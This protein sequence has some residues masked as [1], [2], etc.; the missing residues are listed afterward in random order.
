MRFAR[1]GRVDRSKNGVRHSEGVARLRRETEYAGGYRDGERS[2]H[3]R[4][5]W[6]DGHTYEGTWRA[7]MRHGAGTE[8]LRSGLSRRCTWKWGEVVRETCT[9]TQ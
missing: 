7:G 9:P 4:F 2:G 6:P 5:T 8:T 3:G 1:R